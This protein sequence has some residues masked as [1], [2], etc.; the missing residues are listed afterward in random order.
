MCHVSREEALRRIALS[1]ESTLKYVLKMSQV[2]G[3]CLWRCRITAGKRARTL[4]RTVATDRAGALR[5][6]C[7]GPPARYAAG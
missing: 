1:S 3:R 4:L 6:E 2:A 5:H 7:F